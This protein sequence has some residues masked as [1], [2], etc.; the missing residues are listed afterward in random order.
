MMPSMRPCVHTRTQI[1]TPLSACS[2]FPEEEFGLGAFSHPD[3]AVRHR[4]IELAT[5]GCRWAAELGARDL[6]VWPQQDGYDYN[7][8]VR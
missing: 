5:D 8:Q 1:R 2:R 7:F 3:D 4:A 6:I